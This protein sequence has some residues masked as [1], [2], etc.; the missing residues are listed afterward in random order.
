MKDKVLDNLSQLVEQAL[1]D[2]GLVIACLII[3]ML[4][5]YYGKMFITDRKYN[6]QIIIRLKEKDLRI[7]ELNYIVLERL[8]K[9]SIQQKD[10]SFFKRLKK[11]FKKFSLKK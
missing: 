11:S 4:V 1:S 6:K 3:G 8:N 2:Y 7:S 9:V 5:G 10:K